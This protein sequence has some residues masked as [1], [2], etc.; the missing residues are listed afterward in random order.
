MILLLLCWT[1]VVTVPQGIA[2][3]A[4]KHNVGTKLPENVA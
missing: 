4:K 2:K 3:V 1:T